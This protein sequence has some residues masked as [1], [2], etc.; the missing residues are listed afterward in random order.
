[1]AAVDNCLFC[2]KRM[3][4]PNKTFDHLLCKCNHVQSKVKNFDCREWHTNRM[5]FT[6]NQDAAEL[7]RQ[8]I[9]G[10]K[11]TPTVYASATE[12][13]EGLHFD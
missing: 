12:A 10:S 13:P 11:L 4:V 8:A 3:S 7:K 2:G 1:M 6:R 5:T 9:K